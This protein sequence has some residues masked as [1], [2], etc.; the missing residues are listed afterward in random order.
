MKRVAYLFGAGVTQAEI[1]YAGF[2]VNLL[3]RDLIGGIQISLED[4][5][6]IGGDDGVWEILGNVLSIE[7]V[8]IEQLISLYEVTGTVAD[9]KAAKFLRKQYM[10]EIT[11]RIARVDDPVRLT[12]TLLAALFEIHKL[13]GAEIGEELSGV[14]TLNYDDFAERAFQSIHQ[15][16]NRGFAFRDSGSVSISGNPCDEVSLLKLHGSLDW[17]NEF[18]TSRRA[19][20]DPLEEDCLWIPPGVEKDKSNYPFSLLWGKAT[21]VLDCDVLRIAGCSLSRNDWQLISLLHSAKRI[22]PAFDIEFIGYHDDG[23]RKGAD[24]PY[25][26]LVPLL[27]IKGFRSYVE[28][29]IIGI[30]DE[31]HR[32]IALDD[33]KTRRLDERVRNT[34]FFENRKSFN[35]LHEWVRFRKKALEQSGVV[36]KG[37]G[38][39]SKV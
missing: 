2:D 1:T 9:T 18:P 39:L 16:F 19:Q 4:S 37:T 7:G 35:C 28:K 23:E 32:S 20:S 3:G 12:P 25:L 15:D 6:S 8:D 34:V 36:L 38:Y 22:R 13:H 31:E 21:E 24:Y 29:E 33:A 10:A 17:K 30:T 11:N 27:Q 26:A 14:L 5:H